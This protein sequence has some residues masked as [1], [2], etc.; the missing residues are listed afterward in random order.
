MRRGWV[1]LSFDV[2]SENGSGQCQMVEVS[3]ISV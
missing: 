2:A 1:W 3:G